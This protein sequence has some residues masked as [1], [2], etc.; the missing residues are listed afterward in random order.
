MDKL[1][2]GNIANRQR[3]YKIKRY[4]AGNRKHN[5]YRKIL[6]QI[7]VS[8]LVVLLIILFKSINTPIT[9]NA[10]S[11]I[12]KILYAE[13]DYRESINKT[14]EYVSKIKDYT[15]KAM[16]VFNKSTRQ[17]EMS[18]PI[19]GVVISSYGENNN[20]ITDNKTFQRGIDIKAVNMKIVKAVDDGVVI[21][22]GESE[23]LGKFIKI[24]HGDD[25]FS[26]Y[27][28]LERIYVKENERIIRG[29]RI[30]EL[31]NL[32]NSYLHFE[33]WID[34][35]LVDPQLYINYNTMSI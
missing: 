17:L 24:S 29:Q 32:Y 33:L 25:I 8:I 31:G 9:N 20:P 34:N 26:F 3:K 23:N 2:G 4:K 12:S 11:F 15:I 35:N 28:N 10:S 13:F 5:I 30:G 14:K 1:Y 21:M 6:A 18:R 16:P 22:T 19:E 7:L 27:S